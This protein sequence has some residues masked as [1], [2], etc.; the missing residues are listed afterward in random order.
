MQGDPREFHPVVRDEIYRIGYE[1]IRNA[2]VHARARRIDVAFDPVTTSPC[3]SVT[4]LA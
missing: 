1:T 3:G 4:G 2:C